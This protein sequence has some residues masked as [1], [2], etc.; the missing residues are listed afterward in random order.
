MSKVFDEIRAD[1]RDLYPNPSK[2]KIHRLLLDPTERKR[3]WED[4]AVKNLGEERGQEYWQDF[5]AG[6]MDTAIER[7]CPGKGLLL[8][9][10]TCWK[11]FYLKKIEGDKKR[12]KVIPTG[13]IKDVE[14]GQQDLRPSPAE[15]VIDDEETKRATKALRAA[16][17][18]LKETDRAVLHL[19]YSRNWEF[20][21]IGC[22]LRLDNNPR[23]WS[24]LDICQAT[25]WARTRHHRALHRL[26]RNLRDFH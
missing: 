8:Y 20:E 10:K 12:T 16:Q 14:G 26:K 15:E 1:L 22:L 5:W 11:H 13:G 18:E 19:R 23:G 3:Y 25:N 2:E 4:C 17:G 24:E 21:P 9:I 7:F 6:G